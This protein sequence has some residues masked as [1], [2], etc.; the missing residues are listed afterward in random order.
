MLL[1]DYY[2]IQLKKPTVYDNEKRRC[3]SVTS[4]CCTITG[5]CRITQA[6]SH[7]S[8]ENLVFLYNRSPKK[9]LPGMAYLVM[10]CHVLC[11]LCQFVV[12][13]WQINA[14]FGRVTE[15]DSGISVLGETVF[16]ENGTNGMTGPSYQTSD[17]LTDNSQK[18]FI[19]Q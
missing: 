2:S 18:A 12:I 14:K 3:L 9:T 15:I 1:C 16:I 11:E 4:W 13:L 17:W 10:P 19:S 5:K 7:N 8:S 6:E